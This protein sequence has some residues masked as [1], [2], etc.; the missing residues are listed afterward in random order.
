MRTS[1]APGGGSSKSSQ[2]MTS[3]P[4][5][6]WMRIALVM[7]VLRVR[8]AGLAQLQW[9]DAQAGRELLER[10]QGSGAQRN[11]GFAGGEE[12]LLAAL[13]GIAHPLDAG[14]RLRAA[15]LAHEL[16]GG[17]LEA[18][19]RAEARNVERHDRLR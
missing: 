3:G 5:L 16:V 6:A 7:S 4:P 2:R 12:I 17:A 9:L 13:A 14:H 8:S 1:P 19:G 15:D 11:A 10:R 18:L